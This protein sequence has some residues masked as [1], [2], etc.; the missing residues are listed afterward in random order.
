MA[1]VRGAPSRRGSAAGT[2][3]YADAGPAGNASSMAAQLLGAGAVGWGTLAVQSGKAITLNVAN[4]LALLV[5]TAVL[6]AVDYTDLSAYTLV[7]AATTLASVV[8]NFLTDGVTAKVSRSVGAKDWA[9]AALYAFYSYLF[10]L[11]LGGA[12]CGVILLLFSPQQ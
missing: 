6:G 5:Q 3:P 12:C 1:A 11:V 9:G 10:A 8:F 4:P 7:S 2:N